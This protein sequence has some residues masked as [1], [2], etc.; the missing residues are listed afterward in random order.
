MKYWYFSE[1]SCD[2]KNLKWIF[3]SY[4]IYETRCVF[5]IPSPRLGDIK[6]TT[7]YI[8]T[9]W[10]E[11]SFQ[12]L[13]SEETCFAY[14]SLP[15]QVNETWRAKPV[16]W[17]HSLSRH[18]AVPWDMTSGWRFVFPPRDLVAWY[19]SCCER[20]TPYKMKDVTIYIRNSMGIN[21]HISWC[22]NFFE[23]KLGTLLNTEYRN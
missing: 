18:G 6:Y 15:F 13:Y 20:K 17:R 4:G 7:R 10:N 2:K 8:N 9:V 16:L 23:K 12:I 14:F 5:H 22:N 1:L 19:F 3:I 21:M 11:N